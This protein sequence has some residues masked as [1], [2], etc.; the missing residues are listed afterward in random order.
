MA[1]SNPTPFSKGILPSRSSFPH[2]LAC[3]ALRMTAFS[4][5]RGLKWR[6]MSPF[7][8]RR[9]MLKLKL[10]IAH[11]LSENP[12]AWLSSQRFRRP[13]GSFQQQIQRQFH[14]HKE[15]AEIF[16]CCFNISALSTPGSHALFVVCQRFSVCIS[17]NGL[18]RPRWTTKR[19]TWRA[20]NKARNVYSHSTFLPSARGS[21]RG[22][23]RWIGG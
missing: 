12:T 14:S 23:H 15:Q 6:A 18:Y 3:R 9:L 8:R 17:S 11:Q 13:E 1:R 22:P 4:S 20:A 7:L 21:D 19:W 10:K 16:R 5:K 2:S